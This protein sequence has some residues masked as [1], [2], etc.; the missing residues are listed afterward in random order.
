MC[1]IAD[2]D[3]ENF[4]SPQ[5]RERAHLVVP[6]QRLDSSET[7]ENLAL[8]I[9]NGRRIALSDERFGPGSQQW[10]FGSPHLRHLAFAATLP[11]LFPL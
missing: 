9:E 4:A 7:A 1:M 8:C 5:V 10:I 2:L 3:R 6:A 11:A